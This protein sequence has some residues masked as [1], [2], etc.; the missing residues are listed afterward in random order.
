[1]LVSLHARMAWTTFG[2]TRYVSIKTRLMRSL[3][4]STPFRNIF[5][6]RAFASFTYSICPAARLTNVQ[7][8]GRNLCSG[9][10]PGVFKNSCSLRESTSMTAIGTFEGTLLRSLSNLS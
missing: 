7:K 5:K 3:M 10:D 8:P 1:M 6:M 4:P 2:L 9:I